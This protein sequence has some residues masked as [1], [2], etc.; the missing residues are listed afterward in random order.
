MSDSDN[1]IL[2]N[3]LFTTY[4]EMPPMLHR[5]TECI[6]LSNEKKI[7]FKKDGVI[8]YR[9]STVSG[10]NGAVA[11]FYPGVRQRLAELFDGDY[12]VGF[13]SVHEAVIYP[14]R[15]KRLSK[16]KETLMRVNA[17][18]DKREMLT[19]NVYRYCGGQNRFVEV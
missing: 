17:L 13:I 16:M 18:C 11:L 5:G 14:V 6:Q 9:L 10:T 12:Y 15:Y 4:S 2:T 1:I 19:N 8:G 7:K 3:A